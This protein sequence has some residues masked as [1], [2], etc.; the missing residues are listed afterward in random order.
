MTKKICPECEREVPVNDRGRF[1]RHSSFLYNRC[2]G[3]GLST[4]SARRKPSAIRVVG[5]GLPGLGK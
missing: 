2:R 5:G 1:E 3:S 4:R